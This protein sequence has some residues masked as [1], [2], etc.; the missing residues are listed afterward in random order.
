MA[1]VGIGSHASVDSLTRNKVNW[2]RGHYRFL[3]RFAD[4]TAT[5]IHGSFSPHPRHSAV[6]SAPGTGT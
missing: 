2:A 4:F 3:D 1:G 6:T 5:M